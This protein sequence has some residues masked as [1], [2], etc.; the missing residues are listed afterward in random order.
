MRCFI[1]FIRGFLEKFLYDI[2]LIDHIEPFDRL[3]TQGMVT[4]KM[5]K[6][7]KT[8]RTSWAFRRR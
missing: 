8:L 5:G 4:K 7:R 1:F 6:H 2:G 3:I